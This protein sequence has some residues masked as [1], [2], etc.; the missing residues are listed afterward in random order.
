MPAIL[1]EGCFLDQIDMDKFISKGSQAYQIMA[2][3]IVNGIIK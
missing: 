1:V 2:D 3:N